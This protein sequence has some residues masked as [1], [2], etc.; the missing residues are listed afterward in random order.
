M[1]FEKNGSIFFKFHELQLSLMFSKNDIWFINKNTST[2]IEEKLDHKMV[3]KPT[4][5]TVLH[6]RI[7]LGIHYTWYAM[8]CHNKTKANLF[9]S[10]AC[11]VNSYATINNLHRALHSIL[12]DML[13]IVKKLNTNDNKNISTPFLFV[14]II[15]K[16]VIN[17]GG[18]L[19]K[20]FQCAGRVGRVA[21][22]ISDDSVWHIPKIVW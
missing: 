2:K 13:W 17:W 15:L 4:L 19:K 21:V 9:L 8:P 3:Q 11:I 5:S 1:I 18:P 12:L 7:K 6:N 16:Q 20:V 22:E 10:P 14:T